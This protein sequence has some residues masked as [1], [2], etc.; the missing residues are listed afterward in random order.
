M[1][2]LK[3]SKCFTLIAVF[4]LFCGLNMN[5]QGVQSFSDF[6]ENDDMQEIDV[7]YDINT[8]TKYFIPIEDENG[9]LI[10]RY[11]IIIKNEGLHTVIDICST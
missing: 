10:R 1:N 9:E 2:E 6:S 4:L 3:L 8:N 11:N 7:L 5:G